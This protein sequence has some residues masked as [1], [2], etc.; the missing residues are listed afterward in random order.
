MNMIEALFNYDF[1]RNSFIAVLL[2]SLI[3]GI[4]GTIIVEKRLVSLSGGIAHASF[5]GIGLG[6][7]L[8]IEPIIGGLL[9]ATVASLSVGQ[10]QRRTD[11]RADTVISMFWSAGMALGILF[12]AMTPGY[13]PDMTSYLFGDILTVN[14]L[15]IQVMLGLVVLTL[16]I[17]ISIY[18]YWKL[19]LF[20]EEYAKIMG[21]KTVLLETILYILI[22]LSIVILTK[23]VGIILA[24]ALLTIPTSTAKLYTNHLETIMVLSTV[25]GII[26]GIGGLVISYYINIPSG[27]SIILTAIL[28]YMIL[29]LVKK[30]TTKRIEE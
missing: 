26:F 11:V 15:Y 3:T 28:G 19:Y 8:N 4:M 14:S 20:D 29:V 18:S 27:A 23:V 16:I 12:I 10:I 21:I 24:L 5:G 1:I 2:A 13:P 17:I 25:F 30:V 22:A 6:Y 7:L 9:F